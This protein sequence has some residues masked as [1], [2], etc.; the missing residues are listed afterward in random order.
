MVNILLMVLAGLTGLFIVFNAWGHHL[1]SKGQKPLTADMLSTGNA[2]SVSNEQGRQIGYRVFG[3]TQ[4]RAP[5]LVAVHGSGIESGVEVNIHGKACEALGVRGIAIDLPGYGLSDQKPGRTVIDWP[6]EDLLP[7][8]AQEGVDQFMIC[9]HSQGTPHAMAAALK[10]PQRCLALGLN[11]PL[12]PAFLSKE[13]NVKAAVGSE[14]LLR[15]DSLKRYW[16]GWY[17]A[18]YHLGVVALGAWALPKGRPKVKSDKALM[19]LFSNGITDTC[20]RGTAGHCWESALDVCYEWGFDPRDISC[21]N[22]V[23]L[24]AEDDNWCPVEGSAFLLNYFSNKGDDIRITLHTEDS[25]YGHFTY[26]RGDYLLPE[27]SLTQRLL[28]LTAQAD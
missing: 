25:G 2:R 24:H 11:A 5:V 28:N 13:A 27:N 3:S 14:G 16:M 1:R 4:P 8:L 21:K 23:L 18:V 9:G 26:C 6:G 20:V 12:L 22:I 19:T 7:V 10:L 15:T 17:F